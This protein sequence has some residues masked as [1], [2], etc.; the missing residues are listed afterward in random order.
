MLEQN[1]R[2]DRQRV[3]TLD[4]PGNR[5]QGFQQRIARDLLQLHLFLTL[6][7]GN[8]RRGTPGITEIVLTGQKVGFN[9]PAV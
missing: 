9:R 4:D 1:V 6:M 2:E 3:P 8:K 7:M 5:L